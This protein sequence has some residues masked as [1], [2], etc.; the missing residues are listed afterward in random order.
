MQKEDGIGIDIPLNTKNPPMKHTINVPA[1]GYSVVQVNLSNPGAWM[2]H[3]H[4]DMH[5]TYVMAMSN[6]MHTCHSTQKWFGFGVL[7]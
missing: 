1:Y 4:V 2:F 7:C 5:L 6:S 3:C